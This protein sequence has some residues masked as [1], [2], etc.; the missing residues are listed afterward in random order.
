[1][2]REEVFTEMLRVL[3]SNG[4]NDM[5]LAVKDGRDGLFVH[6]IPFSDIVFNGQDTMKVI[7]PTGKAVKVRFCDIV[8]IESFESAVDEVRD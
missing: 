2:N 8:K 6:Y 1:M 4:Y 3:R 7:A 5:V